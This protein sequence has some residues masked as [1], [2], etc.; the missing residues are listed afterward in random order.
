MPER[1]A[2]ILKVRPDRVDE[3]VAAH[4]EVWPAMRD[5]LHAAGIRNYTIFRDGTTM[6]GYFEAD[7]VDVADGF[8]AEQEVSGRWREAMSQIV[9]E[10]FATDGTTPLEPIF[11]LD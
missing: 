8:M 10:P 7:D 11:R 4:A 5:A 1:R 3:Y 9:A 2:F 6:F